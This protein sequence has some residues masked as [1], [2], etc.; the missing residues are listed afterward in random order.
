MTGFHLRISEDLPERPEDED[1]HQLVALHLGVVVPHW[2][3][4]VGQDPE[5]CTDLLDL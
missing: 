2:L 1:V 4:H 3:D 5:L